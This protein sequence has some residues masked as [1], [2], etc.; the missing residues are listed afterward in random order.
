MKTK[1]NELYFKCIYCLN[2]KIATDF[3]RE[4]VIPESFGRFKKSM[5]LKNTVCSECN[6]YFSKYL[7]NDLGRD[8]IYGVMDRSRAGVID[9][10]DFINKKKHKKKLSDAYILHDQ[11]GIL[12]VDLVNCV[13]SVQTQFAV[14][15]ASQLIVMN[16]TKGLKVN[17]RIDHRLN[18]RFLEDIGLYPKAGYLD[19]YFPYTTA[20]DEYEKAMPIFKQAGIHIKIPKSHLFQI[21]M[22]KTAKDLHFHSVIN[23]KILRAFSKVAF[24]YF[25]HE[26][27]KP[28]ALSNYF[29][30]IRSYIRSGTYVGYQV[31]RPINQNIYYHGQVSGSS[32]IGH[33]VVIQQNMQRDISVLVSF[34]NSHL[35]EIKLCRSYPFLIPETGSFFDTK[36]KCIHT[37]KG[38]KLRVF[39]TLN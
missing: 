18:R 33:I 22:G 8:S 11:Y 29:D 27:G 34:F 5:T 9:I 20:V 17:F 25:A 4:H 19:I 7:E 37:H 1:K 38:H 15:I 6:S 26:Y 14:N 31:V 35:Y 39:S 24:N 36:H 23:Q 10:P 2:T 3:N 30:S 28:A 12:L 32:G 21:S 16:S 13:Q